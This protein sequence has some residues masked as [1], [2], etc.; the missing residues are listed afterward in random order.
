M[1][2]DKVVELYRKKIEE[3]YTHKCTITEVKAIK[4]PIKKT[5]VMQDVEIY[6]E[7]PCRVSFNL[8]KVDEK[9]LVNSSESIV[10]LFIAP[11][12]LIKEGSKVTAVVNGVV[13]Q[14]EC[15]TTPFLYPTHNEYLLKFVKVVN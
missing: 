3:F 8:Q 15:S 13:T 11:E 9:E 4:D 10:K 12:V 14:Y 7:I 6:K 1:Q 5:T 2:K